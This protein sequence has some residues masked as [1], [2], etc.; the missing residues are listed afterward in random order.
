MST[1]LIG[2]P[3]RAMAR[4]DDICLTPI[5]LSVGYST[6]LQ[7]SSNVMKMLEAIKV[8]VQKLKGGARDGP[9]QTSPVK[10]VVPRLPAT[11]SVSPKTV[12]K[13]LDQVEDMLIDAEDSIAAMHSRLDFSEQQLQRKLNFNFR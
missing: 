2:S 8:D 4:V 5:N 13:Q 11:P 10:R 7:A 3:P 12:Q 9:R 6:D 1:C